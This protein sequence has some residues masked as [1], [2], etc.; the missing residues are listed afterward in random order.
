MAMLT[1]LGFLGIAEILLR[2]GDLQEDTGAAALH[3]TFR[4]AVAVLLQSLRVF[5][6][7][8]F[9]VPQ[10]DVG[11]RQPVRIGVEVHY[12]HEADLGVVVAF[13]LGIRLPD[14]VPAERPV[15]VV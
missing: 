11:L 7:L 4:L 12:V 13:E 2:L 10:S 15:V 8:E 1:L 14:H 6:S 9:D 3:E 5:P